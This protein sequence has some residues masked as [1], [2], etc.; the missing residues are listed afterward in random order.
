MSISG[1]I[2]FSEIGLLIVNIVWLPINIWFVSKLTVWLKAVL[3]VNV[4]HQNWLVQG[5]HYFF[6][7]RHD[8][9][10]QPS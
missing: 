7:F 4:E 1:Q 6:V 9:Q 10:S 2:K 8:V 5:L 3:P